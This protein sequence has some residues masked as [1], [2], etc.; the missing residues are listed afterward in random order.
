M[1]G[2]SMALGRQIK[3]EAIQVAFGFTNRHF[4]T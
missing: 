3:V 1:T 4:Q 2:W